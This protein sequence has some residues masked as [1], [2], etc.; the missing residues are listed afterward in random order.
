MYCIRCVCVCLLSIVHVQWFFYFVLITLID[1]HV[2]PW[3]MSCNFRIAIVVLLISFI[4]P[5]FYFVFGFRI[6]GLYILAIVDSIVAIWSLALRCQNSET[7]FYYLI[8]ISFVSPAIVFFNIFVYM[9]IQ[10]HKYKYIFIWANQIYD[11]PLLITVDE[12]SFWNGF[13]VFEQIH[14][15]IVI[16]KYF[17]FLFSLFFPHSIVFFC[18]NLNRPL[19]VCRLKYA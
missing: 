2:K 15:L 17:L 12:T 13:V 10:M 11:E 18:M 8:M 16:M 14:L 19:S 7:L 4:Q 5:H 6:S 1:K 3:F 9:R